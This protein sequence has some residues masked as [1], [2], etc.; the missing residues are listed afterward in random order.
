MK[1]F[2]LLF[3]LLIVFNMAANPV[4][5]LPPAEPVSF[6]GGGWYPDES[7]YNL[8]MQEVIA[9]PRYNPFL[10]AYNGAYYS[11]EESYSE[12][13]ENI[14]EWQHY[15]KIPYDQAYYL[16]MKS[17]VED[18]KALSKG[19][20]VSDKN[21]NFADKNFIEE[22]KQALLYL[23]YAKYLAP[24]MA[25]V[26]AGYNNYWSG[27]P[28]QT[29]EDLDY[30]KVI[31]VLEQSYKAETEK[32][33]KLRYGYQLVRFAHYNLDFQKAIDYFNTYVEPL[34][35]KPIM[36]YYA[37]DQKGGAERGLGNY[38]QANEDFFEFFA[39]TKNHKDQAYSSM[40]VT[41]DLDFE[42]LLKEA[43]SDTA[44][45]DVLMLMG[46]QNFNDPIE[47]MKTIL[48]KT[49]DAVQA[50]VL[51]AR[52]INEIE[53]KF[54]PIYYYCS[55]NNPDC[56]EDLESYKLPVFMNTE[57]RSFLDKTLA[58]S[59]QQSKNTSLKDTDFWY[60]T[61][62]YLYF[63]QKDYAL[64]EENLNRVKGEKLE[65][66]DQKEKLKTLLI[67]T[68]APKIT[69]EF[70]ETLIKD[71]KSYFIKGEGLS[72]RY[73]SIA[74]TRDFIV[75][76]LAN[77]Y[78]L[79]GDYAKSFLLQNDIT[80]LESN[81]NLIL[82]K[83]IETFYHKENKNDFE[84]FILYNLDPTTYDYQQK[85][86][87]RDDS[88]NF[89]VY[90][91]NMRGNIY[92]SQ[93]EF[94][95]ALME[96]KQVPESFKLFGQNSDGYDGFRGVPNTVFGYNKIECYNCA[97]YQVMETQYLADF[98]F[99]K[100][101][102]N[103]RELSETLV[104]LEKIS[105]GTDEEAANANYLIGNFLYN[106]SL[107]GYYRE[108]LTFD[109]NNSSDAKFRSFPSKDIPLDTNR[110]Y[111]KDYSWNPNFDTNFELPIAYFKKGIS[112]TENRELE[113]QLLFAASK[114]EQGNFYKNESEDPDFIAL[115]K[116]QEDSRMNYEEYNRRYF[117]LKGKKYRH[118]FEKLSEYGDTQFYQTVETNCLYFAYYLN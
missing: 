48:E 101:S 18:V 2:V 82:L 96:F 26:N 54:L 8:F 107:I 35:Y 80:A 57:D 89:D 110:F 59:L 108:L 34:N 24:Y 33:L 62:S 51:M 98:E 47:T 1:K 44:R 45:N 86:S 78:Y 32:E 46:Y 85:K 65:Y 104:S 50:K 84:E 115:N 20:T 4:T 100:K 76:I 88:F 60:L 87:I 92:L 31:K 63:I 69:A 111:F 71:F 9:A 6:C 42:K 58:V 25:V 79:Q 55:Y 53:R 102:M 68:E 38:M 97:D 72:D 67:I 75:D 83:D 52:A 73:Q 90:A 40:K 106:T 81:P 109:V 43:K 36:Y 93:G 11:S 117:E 7:Y 22:Y 19:K 64:S 105:E 77:R 13:N 3:S 37:L 27:N 113:A 95:N 118:Y 23:A 30:K 10:L 14:E 56:K 41:Q 99:I 17:A 49:P 39:H 28:N 12:K 21:L 16:V 29:V 70:E 114:C 74:T 15:L 5:K 91:A 94:D 61:T 116:E 66:K 112:K 103:K